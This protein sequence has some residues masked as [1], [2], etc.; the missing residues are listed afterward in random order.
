M[1]SLWAFKSMRMAQASFGTAAGLH[2]GYICKLAVSNSNDAFKRHRGFQT[3]HISPP[4][5]LSDNLGPDPNVLNIS[6]DWFE[7]IPSFKLCVLFTCWCYFLKLLST[8]TRTF[9]FVFHGK[10]KSQ[11][12]WMTQGW[13]STQ[14][15]SSQ[16]FTSAAKFQTDGRVHDE[17][18]CF[19]Y[20]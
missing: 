18:F 7:C 14:L 13:K 6:I 12:L 20:W 19:F 15:S 1:G 5:Q 2:H 9:P 10:R 8:S 3:W 11:M 16:T 4:Q 17:G